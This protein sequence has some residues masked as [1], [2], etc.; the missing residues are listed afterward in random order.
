M[1]SKQIGTGKCGD[2]WCRSVRGVPE[3]VEGAGR[4]L[5]AGTVPLPVEGTS[6]PPLLWRCS[7]LSPRPRWLSHL[8]GALEHLACEIL[9]EDNG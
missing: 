3:G 6:A 1:H 2:P 4:A 5:P 7:L 9:A 8:P